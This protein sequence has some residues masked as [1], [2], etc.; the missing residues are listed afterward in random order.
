MSRESIK[1][2]TTPNKRLAPKRK[3]NQN[4]K[5]AL[6]YKGSCLK[7]GKATFTHINV[8]KLFIVYEQDTWWR[9]LN[10]DFTLSVCLCGAVN[11]TKNAGPDIAAVV[12]DLMHAQNF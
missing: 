1:P 3:R 11:L 2:P 5:L 6:G 9:G 12:L 4:P 7:Q 10:S 8:V